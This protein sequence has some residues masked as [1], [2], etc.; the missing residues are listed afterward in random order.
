MMNDPIADMLARIKNAQAVGKAQ[1]SFPYSKVKCAIL[2]V[3]L[4]EGYIE[5]YA[6]DEQKREI[7]MVIRYYTGLP[8]IERLARVSRCGLRRY[9]PSRGIGRVRGGLGVSVISTSRG[10]MSDH[11]ARAL[12]LGGE[13]LCEVC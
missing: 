6:P 2:D 8:V 13:I 7:T 3:L 4:A 1:V 12:G 5:G 9:S 11:Q 10:V